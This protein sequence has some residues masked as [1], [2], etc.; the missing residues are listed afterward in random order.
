MSLSTEIR[1]AIVSRLIWL[2][3]LLAFLAALAL[4]G[5]GIWFSEIS[6]QGALDRHAVWW[7]VALEGAKVG[8]LIVA[9]VFVAAQPLI[10]LVERG[11]SA[12][13]RHGRRSGRED[14]EK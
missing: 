1:R 3:I 6:L 14:E 13:W 2:I 12:L 8:G 11:K 9:F 5:L 7:V 10:A 4:L